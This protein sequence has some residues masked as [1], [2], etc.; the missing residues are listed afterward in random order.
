VNISGFF[1]GEF[2]YK[3]QLTVILNIDTDTHGRGV[4]H[5]SHY[6][7]A[8]FGFLVRS[9]AWDCLKGHAANRRE[10][11]ALVS[12][13]HGAPKPR[14]SGQVLASSVGQVGA[15]NRVHRGTSH[16]ISARQARRGLEFTNKDISLKPGKRTC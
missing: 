2:Q 6:E 15:P 14:A 16:V 5:A 13:G 4:D 3:P 10:V 9:P 1:L 12:V 11:A 7:S 8:C